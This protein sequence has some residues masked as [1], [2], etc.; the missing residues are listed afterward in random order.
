KFPGLALIDTERQNVRVKGWAAFLRSHCKEDGAITRISVHQ[1]SLPDDGAAL[2]SW[3]ERHTAPDAPAAA[4]EAL[5]ELM[6]GAG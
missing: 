4:V 3:T 6:Q 2:R 1:R 5:D